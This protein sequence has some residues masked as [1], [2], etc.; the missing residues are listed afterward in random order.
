MSDVPDV[1]D[2]PDE[3]EFAKKTSDSHQIDIR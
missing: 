3:H 2:V 1:P